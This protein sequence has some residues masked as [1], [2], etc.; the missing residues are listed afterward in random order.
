MDDQT[1]VPIER[2]DGTYTLA[3]ASRLTGLSVEAL[4]QRMRRGKIERVRG[5][6][7]GLTRVRLSAADL[8]DIQQSAHPHERSTVQLSN[9]EAS[10]RSVQAELAVVQEA[11]TREQGRADA[12]EKRAEAERQRA[13]AAVA[14]ADKRAEELRHQGERAARA[15]GEI[16][17]LRVALERADAALNEARKPAW[18]RW[19]G[20]P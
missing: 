16:S 10:D 8:L 9:E 4:R 17:G 2:S 13:D 11:L 19:L 12:A 14:L 1:D 6:N 20:L 3:E 5:G 7:D 15:E 18:R